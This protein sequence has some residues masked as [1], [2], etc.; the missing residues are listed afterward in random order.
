M[1]LL[2][3]VL[4]GIVLAGGI[5]YLLPH[6]HSHG[7]LVLPALGGIVSAVVWAAL[8]WLGWRFDGG[9]IWV[10]SLA[11]AVAVAAFVGVR[12]ARRRVAADETLLQQLSKP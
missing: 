9:W 6:R 11:I 10:V 1:E 4:S 7:V 8:T 5:R 12:I 2:F 3:V